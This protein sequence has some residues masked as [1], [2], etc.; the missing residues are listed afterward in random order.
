[1]KV[2]IQKIKPYE[3]DGVVYHA[4]TCL[5]LI[6]AFKRGKLKFKALARHTY[7]GDRLDEN[8]LGLNSIGYWDANEPQDW[9]LDWHRNEGIEFHFLESGSMPYAQE[10]KEVLLTPNHLTITRPWEAHKVGNPFIGMG[11]FYWVIIDL[12]VRRPHQE[13]VWP[14]WITLTKDDLLRLT[15]ILRQNKKSILKTDQRVRDCFKRINQAINTDDQ[16][17]NASK[18]R[19]LIN[20]LLILILDLLNTENIELNESLTDSSRSVKY[21]LKELDKKLSEQWTIDLMAKSAGVGL[22][23][24]T[25]HCKQ[26]TNVTPMRYLTMRRL[27][28]SKGILKNNPNLTVSDVAYMCGFTTSQYFSTV[29]KKHEKCSPNEFRARFCIDQN[30]SAY[31]EI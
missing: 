9:G 6:D 10:D 21:F 23:R 8:T 31:P 22:T 11:K 15:T 13:W 5:P 19:L 3:A 4:D 28:M 27:E 12:G 24:F 17:S 26:L 20:Y 30:I 1:M 16:G 18:I 25:H 7:P 29:F 14:D 2:N